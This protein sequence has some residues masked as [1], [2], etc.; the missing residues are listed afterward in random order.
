MRSLPPSLYI[1]LLC[2][3][4]LLSYLLIFILILF[5]YHSDSKESQASR[6]IQYTVG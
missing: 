4:I 3:L 5:C 1:E 2:L 6:A